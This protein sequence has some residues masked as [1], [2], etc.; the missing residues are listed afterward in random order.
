[1]LLI[2]TVG[3]APEPLLSSI[4]WF[5]PDKVIFLCSND[6][7]TVKG[8]YTQVVGDGI[9]KQA[10]LEEYQYEIEKIDNYD[11]LSY[12]YISSCRLINR[13]HEEYPRAKITVDYTGGTKSMA[14]GLAAAALDDGQCDV[15]LVAGVRKDLV[16]VTDG[17]Q[18][19]RLISICSIQIERGLVE[20]RRLLKQFDYSAVKELLESLVFQYAKHANPET[21]QHLHRGI[22][23]SKAFEAWDCFEHELAYSMLET[24]AKDVVQ[25]KIFLKYI[26]DQRGHGY[27]MVED[28]VRNAQRRAYRKRYDDAIARLYRAIEMLAQ[29]RLEKTGVN[30][31]DVDMTKVK[32]H[33]LK[34]E[35]E[36]NRDDKEKIKVGLQK[37]WKLLEDIDESPLS[38]YYT[39]NKKKIKSFLEVRNQSILAHGTRPV[40]K[41]DYT[42]YGEFVINFITEGVK[43]IVEFEGKKYS[44]APQFLVDFI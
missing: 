36:K 15:A 6:S 35:F 32:S 18:I 1:M 4:E 11:N 12:C 38:R 39:Q 23:L 33:I 40:S 21:I 2:L 17:T 27:E 19:P 13:L 10:N 14:A 3:S 41:R 5:K 28:L 9:V 42:D 7:G 24:Y 29:K 30:T 16:K 43:K 44:I 25:H 26:I 34:S 8:S 20:G 37:A 31:S 22:T